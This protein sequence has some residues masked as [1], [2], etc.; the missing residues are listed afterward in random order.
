M[1]KLLA[2]GGKMP[3]ELS[4]RKKEPL[5]GLMTDL[6]LRNNVGLPPLKEYIKLVS[7]A[8]KQPCCWNKNLEIEDF[9]QNP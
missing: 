2:E 6:G 4:F 1:S 7:S 5:S 8:Y 9:I 3:E